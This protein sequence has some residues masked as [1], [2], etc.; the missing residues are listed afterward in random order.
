LGLFPQKEKRKRKRKRL[1]PKSCNEKKKDGKKDVGGPKKGLT[2]D[3]G[4]LA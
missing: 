1:T 2:S 3:L 4:E